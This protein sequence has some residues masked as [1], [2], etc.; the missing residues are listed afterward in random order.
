MTKMADSQTRSAPSA[1]AMKLGS[2]GVSMRLTFT[3]RHSKEASDAEMDMPRA[4]SS[5]SA[6]ETVVP[7]ATEPSRVV[8]PA[9]N[10]RASCSDVFPLPRWPTSATLRILSAACGMPMYSSLPGDTAKEKKTTGSVAQVVALE[11]RLQAQHGLRVQLGDAALRH[12]EHLADLPQRQVLVVVEGDHEL[13]ALRQGGDGVGQAVLDLRLGEH[14]L[15]VRRV[16][17]LEGVQQRHGVARGV[18]H[19][20][21][22][23]Q[24]HDGGV[25]DLDQRLLEVVRGDVEL[26]RHL[27]VRGR[28]VQPV[29]ELGVDLLDLAGAGAHG[30]R[31]PVQGAQLVDDRALDAGDRVG[32]ELDLAVEV[33]ALDRIDQAEQAIGDEVR[34]FHMGRQAGGHPAGHVLDQWR[35]GDDELLTGLV[36]AV[37]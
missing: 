10:S 35:V 9:S 6:S 4:F 11:A 5:S 25:G 22:L 17:V 32:L 26:A 34:L 2:P 27:V 24:R 30:A 3:S 20:P 13:L 16:R 31:H 21:Q 19:R 7:S 1:S 8:A 29:L 14:L 37:R 28:A 33:E 12:P 18:R 36:G 15:R 23:V